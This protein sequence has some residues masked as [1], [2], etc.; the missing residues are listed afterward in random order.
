MAAVAVS[1]RRGVP[2]WLVLALG[3]LYIVLGLL[4]LFQPAITTFWL[5]VF[6]GAVWFVDGVF[7]LISLFTDRSRML[8]KIITGIIGIWAG[9]VILSQPLLSTVLVPTVFVFVIAVSGIFL[10]VARLIQAF[11][12]GGWGMGALGVA[13][14]L[15]G[16]FL[17]FNPL[18][19]AL[20][21][22]F[23]LGVIAL[24]GGV[25]TIIAAFQMR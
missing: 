1:S 15:I 4:L 23:A 19:G 11:Q 14:I 7:D 25:L 21:L 5:V 18:A 3:I 12:G 6:I 17:L 2:W 22:P 8:W 13:S 20:A 24:V 10:G 9:L 16:L